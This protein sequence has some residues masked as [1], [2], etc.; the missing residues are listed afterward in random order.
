MVR[1]HL[2]A[3]LF[4]I[5]DL[6]QNVISSSISKACSLII[7]KADSSSS[8]SKWDGLVKTDSKLR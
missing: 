4:D 3:D 7:N 6:L 2:I 5:V 1:C 8:K